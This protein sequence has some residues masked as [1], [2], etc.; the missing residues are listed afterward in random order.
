MYSLPLSMVS[1]AAVDAAVA[2]VGIENVE[3]RDVVEP[4]LTAEVWV[5]VKVEV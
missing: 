5:V 4:C 3:V 2:A 1:S